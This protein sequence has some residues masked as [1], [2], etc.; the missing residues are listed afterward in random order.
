MILFSFLLAGILLIL[1]ISRY[2]ENEKLFWQLFVSFIGAFAATVAV[3]SYLDNKEKQ[4]KIEYLNTVP[5][6]A[7][8]EGPCSVCTLADPFITVTNEVHTSDPVSKEAQCFSTSL[9]LSKIVEEIR[10]QPLEPFDTS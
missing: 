3:V 4:D 9:I 1:G 2:N 5:T 8:D 10:G 6:Q 7:P